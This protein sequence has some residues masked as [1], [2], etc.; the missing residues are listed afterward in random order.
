[1]RVD[2]DSKIPKYLQIREWIMGMITRGEIAVGSRLPT[3]DELASGFGVNRMTVR[4]ALDELV[5]EEMIVRKRGTGTILVSDKPKGYVYELDRITSFNDDMEIHG[6]RPVH[7]LPAKEVRKAE[8]DLVDKLAL[9]EDTRVIYT[10][11]VKH[12]EDEP[13]LIERSFVPYE[14]FSEL[15]GIE[16]VGPFY[17]LLVE[18]FNVTLHHSIQI[19][20]AV[21]AG[22]EETKIFGFQHCE[23]CMLL[24]SVIYDDNDIP[25]EALSAHYRGDRYRFKA[26]SGE[27]LFG[28]PA[29]P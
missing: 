23:P 18:K 4:Q 13:V 27:Y 17:R 8:G 3:E 16:E 25:V 21:M 19:F 28:Q 29:G 9:G 10:L 11:S 7:K 6:I 1:M 20:S 26:Q 2:P 22:W 14:A 24:E 12:V 5:V 15:M